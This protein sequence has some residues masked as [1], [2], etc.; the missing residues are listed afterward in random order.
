MLWHMLINGAKMVECFEAKNYPGVKQ[1]ISFSKT[2]Y[3][4]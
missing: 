3:V 2:F 4:T 1:P